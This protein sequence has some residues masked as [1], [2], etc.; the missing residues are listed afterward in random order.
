MD[1]QD[2]SELLYLNAILISSP[3]NSLKFN[4]LLSQPLSL[5]RPKET[6]YHLSSLLE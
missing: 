1:P 3:M 4:I 2:A 6:V 5:V